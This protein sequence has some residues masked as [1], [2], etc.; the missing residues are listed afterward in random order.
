MATSGGAAPG[1]AQHPDHRQWAKPGD[2]WVDC[3]CGSQH[4]G[5]LGAAGLLLTD[6]AIRDPAIVL[7]HR[8]LWS[9]QGGTWGIPGG[10]IAPGESAADAALREAREE[11]G[12]PAEAVRV[13]ASYLLQHPD[14]TYTTIVGESARRF[15]PIPT[16][17]E[18]LELAW[19]PVADVPDRM[20]LP[21]FAAAWP[22]LL[23]L[24]GRR[25]LVVVD[26]A[27]VI[28]TRPDGW[29]RDRPTAARRLHEATRTALESGLSAGTLKLPGEQWWPDVLLVLE[30]EAR[31]AEL[32]GDA[33]GPST[34]PRVRVARAPASGDDEIVAQTSA[35][36]ASDYTDAVVVTADRR[37]AERVRGA[38]A[39]VASPRAF[40]DALT[41][42]A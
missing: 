5:L 4:W 27:N 28:G 31:A 25:V 15:R 36:L 39:A 13:W 2:G 12:V 37:L 6:G 16:D 19:V 9:H 20:L 1:S 23:R 33:G 26:A 34:E 10:A 35:A 11:A 32:E 18:S 30:G 21:A 40:L 29:W 3:R 7:Q 38:G 17:T 24:V 8:S 42:R 14:W 41:D 22:N